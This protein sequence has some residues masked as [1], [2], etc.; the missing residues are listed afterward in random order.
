MRRMA[1]GTVAAVWAAL[2]SCQ[3]AVAQ[4]TPIPA[5]PCVV[6]TGK[7]VTIAVD[8]LAAVDKACVEIRQGRTDVVW[9]G[10]ADVK[11]L[12]IVFK[13]GATSPPDAP[14]CAGS[15]CTLEKAKHATK[16]GVF[17]YAVHVVRQDGSKVEVDPRLIIQ[18]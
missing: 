11:E 7:S 14:R 1:S 12:R 2:I 5:P 16:K 18:P 3:V 6:V 15:V 13:A 4:P 9:Q 10:G 17:D 8:R